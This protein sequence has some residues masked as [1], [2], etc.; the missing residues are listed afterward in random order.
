MK[1]ENQA[2]KI[3][4]IITILSISFSLLGIIFMFVYAFEDI[5]RWPALSLTILGIVLLVISFICSFKIKDRKTGALTPFLFIM[6][7]IAF[8]LIV[9]NLF[10]LIFI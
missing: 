4:I 10:V 9:I 2:R 3:W 5:L 6:S 8:P 7:C 1:P